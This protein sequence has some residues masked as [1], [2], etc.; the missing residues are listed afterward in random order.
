MWGTTPPWLITTSPRSL[1]NLRENIRK[2]VDKREEKVHTLHRF[3]WQ[4]VSD[5]AQYAASCYP[6]LRYQRVRESQLQGIREQRRGTL[7]I[8]LVQ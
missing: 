7:K 8:E 6:W 4:A 1:F 2:G 3:G 5:G